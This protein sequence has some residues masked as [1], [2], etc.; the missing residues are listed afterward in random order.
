M[1]VVRAIGTSKVPGSGQACG[2]EG[3]SG[4][5]CYQ[6]PVTVSAM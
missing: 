2:A 4:E 3:A 1:S 6:K 5:E